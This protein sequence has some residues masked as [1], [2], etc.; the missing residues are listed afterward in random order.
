[1]NFIILIRKGNPKITNILILIRKINLIRK[2]CL[3]I[4]SILILLRKTKLDMQISEDLSTVRKKLWRV[5]LWSDHFLG[6]F[7]VFFGFYV[8]R[9]WSL[10]F[11]IIL[12]LSLQLQCSLAS[13][14]SIYKTRMWKNKKLCSC[15]NSFCALR[16]WSLIIKSFVHVSILSVS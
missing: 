8:F 4:T 2:G 11:H 10:I 6:G 7:I 16:F 1:M 9:F 5:F 12:L 14:I 3:K 15:F 13:I